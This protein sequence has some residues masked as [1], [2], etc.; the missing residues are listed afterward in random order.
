MHN[1]KANRTYGQTP[2][3]LT[4]RHTG[5]EGSDPRQADNAIAASNIAAF[6]H[7]GNPNPRHKT[8]VSTYRGSR[9]ST[10]A[11]PYGRILG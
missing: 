3:P 6:S 9:P 7:L 4:R 11:K 1:V 2:R 8:M 10:M 5:D